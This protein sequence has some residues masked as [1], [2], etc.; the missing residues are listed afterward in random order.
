MHKNIKVKKN[1]CGNFKIIPKIIVNTSIK[2]AIKFLKIL[3]LY[4]ILLNL[5]SWKNFFITLSFNN[6]NKI[7]ENATILIAQLYIPKDSLP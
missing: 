6:S 1:N 7:E 5:Y 2:S 4:T 3:T